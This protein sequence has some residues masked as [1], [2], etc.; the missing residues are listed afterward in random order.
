MT[1]DYKRS[2]RAAFLVVAIAFLLYNIYQ[3]VLTTMIVS[4]FPLIIE[5]IPSLIQSTNPSLQLALIVAQELAGAIGAYMRLI[6]AVFAMNFAILFFRNKPP[7]LNKLSKALL[8]ESL[9]FLLYFPVVFNHIIGSTISASPFVNFNTGLSYLLQIALVFPPL[10]ILSLKL[11]KD[12]R[13]AS[14]ISWILAAVSLYF[15]GAWIKHCFMWIYGV[16]PMQTQP[17]II[18][19][20][21]SINS[22]LT[23]LMAAI[24]SSISWFMIKTNRGKANVRIYLASLAV[25]LAGAYF[26]IYDVIS[27]YS[28]IFGAY[29]LLND[30]WMITLLVLGIA[31]FHDKRNQSIS[32]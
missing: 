27:I 3:V 6:G 31:L 17:T 25:V 5:R 26:V 15:F 2:T 16:L 4:H 19:T 24:V 13:F 12:S 7:Y 30:A 1:F 8:F 11:K 29:L 32:N 14:T 28:P 21:G 22:V 10:F 18:D 23:L 20:I 9:Y